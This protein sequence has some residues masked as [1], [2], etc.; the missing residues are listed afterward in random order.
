MTLPIQI[1][2][3]KLEPSE[4][5]KVKVLREA[6]K[7][8]KFYP[9]IMSC[10]VVIDAPERR[11]RYGTLHQVRIDLGVPGGELVV[12]NEPS[13]HGSIAE[14]QSKTARR[15]EVGSLDKPVE[16]SIHDAFR[17]ARRQLEDYARCQRREVKIHE[18]QQAKVA[19]LSP[20]KGYGMLV[21]ADGRQLY[22]HRNSVVR[23]SFSRMKVGSTV[24]FAEEQGEHGPQA[25]TV[26]IVG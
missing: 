21:T 14:E 20:K 26:R 13:L 24:A 2:F 17:L 11:R 12:N 7:L 23:G 19:E 4:R 6:A 18:A 9:A 3:R 10:R 22:F 1:T 15:L 25:S 5:I 16:R 8:E